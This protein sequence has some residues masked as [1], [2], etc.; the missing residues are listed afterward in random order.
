MDSLLDL[1]KNI[2]NISTTS[3]PQ[4]RVTFQDDDTSLFT[5]FLS[6]FDISSVSSA[7]KHPISIKLDA[8]EDKIKRISKV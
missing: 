7:E 2:A 8:P 3:A 1:V 4:S 5:E 6:C